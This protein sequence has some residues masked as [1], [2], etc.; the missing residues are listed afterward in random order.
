MPKLAANLSF[1]YQDRPFID[2]FAAAAADGFR[3]VEFLFPYDFA[4]EALAV[5]A[6]KAGVRI[7]L[8]NL[9]P[10]DWARG[11]RGL[12]ALAGREKDFDAALERALDYAEI[13]DCPRIHA[14]AGRVDDGADFATYMANL[15]NAAAVAAERRRAL[16]IEPI[17][18]R[19]IPGYFLNRQDEA[20][21]ICKAVGAANLGVQMDM[22]HCQIVEGDVARKIEAFLP[23]VSHMQ[24]A[25]VPDRHEPD[26]GEL[27]YPYLF[28]L[29]DRLGYAGWI[30][31]EY[32]PRGDTSAGLGWAR[33]HL[34]R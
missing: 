26:E 9:P 33:T 19:D 24:I 17:N 2:R 25:G 11:E 13:L 18:T 14:M 8:F 7:V 23:G 27:N 10:G 20:H 29:I 28:D 21:S 22:Y 5:A 16:T 15:R 31:C 34:A 4:A 30:G 1:L 3:G 12:A 32:R 6:R